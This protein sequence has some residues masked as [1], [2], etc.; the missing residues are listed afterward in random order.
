MPRSAGEWERSAISFDKANPVTPIRAILG[1]HEN[2]WKDLQ[3]ASHYDGTLFLTSDNQ[4]VN[5]TSR[6][7]SQ[8]AQRWSARDLGLFPLKTNFME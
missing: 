3:Y 2:N 6:R 7:N 8:S 4:N 1:N 5:R